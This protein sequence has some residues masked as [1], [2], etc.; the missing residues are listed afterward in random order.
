MPFKF[1]IY[2]ED[3]ETLNEVFMDIVVSAA[4][5]KK[6]QLEIENDRNGFSFIIDGYCPNQYFLYLNAKYDASFD[7]YP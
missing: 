7:I 5:F 3:G 4:F 6:K 1:T 2:P